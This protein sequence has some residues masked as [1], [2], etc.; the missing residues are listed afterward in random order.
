MNEFSGLAKGLILL[1]LI[2][3][4]VGVGLLLIDKIPFIGRLPGDINIQ[5]KNGSFYFPLTT[6]ILLSIILTIIL[7]LFFRR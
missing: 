1:G 5:R 4:V 3:V 6:C 7:N 2:I